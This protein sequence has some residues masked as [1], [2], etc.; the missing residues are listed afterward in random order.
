MSMN[1]SAVIYYSFPG[2]FVHYR[3]LHCIDNWKLMFYV[4][5]MDM[6]YSLLINGYFGKNII[7]GTH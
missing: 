5:L 4:E 6:I 3:M 2:S 1:K 7:S